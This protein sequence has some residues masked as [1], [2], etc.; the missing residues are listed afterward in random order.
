MVRRGAEIMH[1][2]TR[3]SR[4]FRRKF[5]AFTLVELLVCIGIIALLIGLL[6][7]ALN[8]SREQAKKATCLANLHSIGQGMFLYAHY[9]HD[10]LPNQNPPLMYYNYAAANAALVG[11]YKTS[12]KGGPGAF[13]C[14]SDHDPTPTDIVTSDPSL[15]NSACTSY[16]FF[17]IYFPPEYGPWLSKLHGR[18]PLAWDID[19]GATVGLGRN[20]NGGGNVVFSDGHAEWWPLKNW[21]MTNWPFPAID[22]YPK[23][24]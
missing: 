7:P 14:P 18:A 16:D 13:W 20:H 17:S 11:F 4:K 21:E 15:P 19:G 8:K 22:F 23:G 10:W 5:S 1:L 9:H 6:L 24:P 3:T 2:A 12:M